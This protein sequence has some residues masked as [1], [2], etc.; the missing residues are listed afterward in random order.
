MLAFLERHKTAM[1]EVMHKPNTGT[2][3][4]SSDGLEWVIDS[5]KQH[6]RALES[7][8]KEL[9]SMNALWQV[10]LILMQI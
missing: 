8:Q 4:S 1:A 9:L 5:A 10:L 2:A 6:V 7:Y 3:Q